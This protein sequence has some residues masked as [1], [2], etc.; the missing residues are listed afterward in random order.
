M[1]G[2][3]DLSRRLGL[4]QGGFGFG[5][6]VRARARARV[7]LGLGLGIRPA[8]PWVRAEWVFSR[9]VP[10]GKIRGARTCGT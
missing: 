5:R 9:R 1:C 6:G 8:S 4:G 2:G 10:V 7:G 3:Q